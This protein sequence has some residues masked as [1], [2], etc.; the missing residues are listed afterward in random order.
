MD[1]DSDWLSLEQA[2]ALANRVLGLSEK[3]L[4]RPLSS[5]RLRRAIRSGVLAALGIEH[6]IFPGRY[7]I[8]RRS[9]LTYIAEN[10]CAI[11]ERARLEA[12]ACGLDVGALPA[13]PRRRQRQAA[14]T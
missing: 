12:E 11:C 3:S 8:S 13:P 7:Y 9:L 5:S 6:Q 4:Y 10:L 2:A 14:K 1:H